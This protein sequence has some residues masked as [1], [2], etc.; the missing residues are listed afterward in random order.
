MLLPDACFRVVRI[1]RSEEEG[2]SSKTKRPGASARGVTRPCGPEFAREYCLSHL[3]RPSA[4]RGSFGRL[5]CPGRDGNQRSLAFGRSVRV[6]DAAGQIGAVGRGGRI[7]GVPL[8]RGGVRGANAGRA[9]VRDAVSAVRGGCRGVRGGAGAERGTGRG[10]S[11][12]GQGRGRD[13][14]PKGDKDG[15]PRGTRAEAGR[16][17]LGARDGGRFAYRRSPT[18]GLP[19]DRADRGHSGHSGH[20]ESAEPPEQGRARPVRPSRAPAGRLREQ[21]RTQAGGASAGCRR[22]SDPP[23]RRRARPVRRDRAPSARAGLGP[24]AAPGLCPPAPSAGSVRPFRPPEQGRPVRRA[25]ALRDGIAGN[26]GEGRRSGTWMRCSAPGPLLRT[27]DSADHR[28]GSAQ[29]APG[30]GNP[31]VR[32]PLPPRGGCGCGWRPAECRGP[33]WWSA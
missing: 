11:P 32:R 16:L 25:G 13:G 7:R 14:S 33:S 2:G 21:D 6:R 5:P 29:A 26:N 22:G 4:A 8:L 15:H 24:S 18:G 28:S 27:T 20:S 3:R 17:T 23:S 30:R 9:G 12:A 19:T 10:S 1:D 31:S